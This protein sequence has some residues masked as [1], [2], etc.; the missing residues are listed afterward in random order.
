MLNRGH[1]AATATPCR[2]GVVISTDP[3]VGTRSSPARRSRSSSARAARRSPCPQL[4]GRT[5]MRPRAQLQQL[6]LDRIEQYKDSDQPADT[7]IEQSPRRGAGVGKDA[8]V[9]LVVSK[10]PPL[11]TRARSHQP[12]VPAGGADAAGHDLRVRI[13]F[14]PNGIVRSQQPGPNT[15]VPPGRPVAL[16]SRASEYRPTGRVAHDAA[17]RAGQGGAAVRRRRRF[18]GRAGL[19]VQLRAAGRCRAGD[20]AQD[21]RFRRRLRRA[22]ACPRTSTPSLLVN[23][24]SPTAATVERSVADAGARAAPRPGDRRPRRGLPRR[25][26][27]RRRSTPRR[28]CIRYA[29]ALLPLLDRAAAEGC[30]RLLVEPSAG[31][32]RSLRPG[33]SDLGPYLAAVDGHP[34]LG[35]CFDT[36][37]AWAAGH[38]LAT[39]GG[40]TA[41]LDALVATVGPGRLQLIHANDSKDPL[42]LHPGPAR[43]DRRR[44]RSGR[45]RSRSC[46]ATRRPPACRSSWRRPSEGFAGHAADIALLRKLRA[47]P[48]L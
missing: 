18:R 35:V 23:L 27:G 46:S 38:D 4:T 13:D 19:R 34:R 24:G 14:N 44:A 47:G 43:D 41:T 22:G 48:P 12:A 7:V 25:Q 20:P 9:K 33:S 31:G 39:P 1:G 30:P 5:S 2:Q 8:E 10:G 17:G 26:L 3:K 32:G 45:P 40:M 36:C 21:A 15:Q 42:R 29:T 16:G 28:R 6:G 37:H 11:V